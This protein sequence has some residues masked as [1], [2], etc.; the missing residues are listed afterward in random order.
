MGFE[1]FAYLFLKG[2]NTKSDYNKTT[3]TKSLVKD[4]ISPR[5]K[6]RLKKNKSIED[7]MKHQV[8]WIL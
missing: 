3:A 6:E 8:P 1:F 4:L 2:V 7:F 5:T